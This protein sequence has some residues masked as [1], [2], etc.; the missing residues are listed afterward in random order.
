MGPARRSRSAQSGTGLSRRHVQV[1]GT[2]EAARQG[3][4]R[5]ADQASHQAEAIRC[6]PARHGGNGAGVQGGQAGCRRARRQRPDGGVRG[7]QYSSLHGVLRRERRQY[8]VLGGAE[9][10]AAARHRNRGAQS[11]RQ[12]RAKLSRPSATRPLPDREAGAARFRRRGIGAAAAIRLVQHFRA[13]A[14]LWLHLSP[15]HAGEFRPRGAVFHQHVLSAQPAERA[16]L[17]LARQGLG[18]RDRRMGR[19]SA[20]RGHRLGR[21]VA[22]RGGRG[23]RPRLPRRHEAQGCRCPDLDPAVQLPLRDLRTEELDSGRRRHEGGGTRHD[24]RSS[25]QP[26]YRSA[27]GTGSGMAFAYWR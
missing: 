16:A 23:T 19:R 25:Y 26:L 21:D 24:R 6:V 13:A 4:P 1:R 11:S 20:R 22:F 7:R 5:G 9:E 3:K 12:D 14:R 18:R 17:L 10:A 2:G 8:S 15:H 27:A